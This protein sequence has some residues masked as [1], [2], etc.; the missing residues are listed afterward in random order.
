LEEECSSKSR[1]NLCGRG[2]VDRKALRSKELR[3]GREENG[4]FIA[5]DLHISAKFQGRK[6]GLV[7]TT[8]QE[9]LKEKSSSGEAKEKIF[10]LKREVGRS[11]RKY[12]RKGRKKLMGGTERSTLITKRKNK[13]SIQNTRRAVERKKVHMKNGGREA[14]R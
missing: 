13:H 3:D 6:G 1:K 14:A 12:P 7:F 2:G 11:N 5:K 10:L 8:K 4:K 9:V